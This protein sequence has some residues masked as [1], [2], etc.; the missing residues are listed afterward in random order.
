[1]IYI[2]HRILSVDLLHHYHPVPSLHAINQLATPEYHHPYCT[3][4]HSLFHVPRVVT[5]GLHFSLGMNI[6]ALQ[7]VMP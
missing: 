2:L 7:P 5:Q 4:G 3:S 1:M 6:L